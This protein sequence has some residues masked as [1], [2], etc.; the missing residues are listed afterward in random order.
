VA[1][2]YALGLWDSLRRYLD[3]GRIELDNM[4]ADLAI[5]SATIEMST[6]TK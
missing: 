5:D 3:D 2:H 4:I 6:S 1:I